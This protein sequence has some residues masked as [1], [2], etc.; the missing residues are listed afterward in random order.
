MSEEQNNEC[1]AYR[2]TAHME[3]RGVSRHFVSEK[4]ACVATIPAVLI[5]IV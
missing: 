2:F 4:V 1:A 5:V 3:C